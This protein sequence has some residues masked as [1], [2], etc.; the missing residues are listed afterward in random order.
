MVQALGLRQGATSCL[1]AVGAAFA[2]WKQNDASSIGE[3][4]RP[5]G[6]LRPPRLLS[7]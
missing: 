7:R 4:E 6:D 1:I 5:I 2:D 3:K